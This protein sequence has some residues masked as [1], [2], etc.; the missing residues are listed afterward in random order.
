M[1]SFLRFI[2]IAGL[3]VFLAF[4]SESQAESTDKKEPGI[5]LAAETKSAGKAEIDILTAPVAVP[6]VTGGDEEK[7]NELAVYLSTAKRTVVEGIIAKRSELPDPRKSDYPNCRFTIDFIG[8]SIL[9]GEP[10]PREFV[11]V[12]DGFEN[13]KML[14]TDKLQE[15]D[16]IQCT[17]IPF[18]CLPEDNQSTQQADDL[19][20]FLLERYYVLNVRTIQAFED[21][22]VMPASAIF[23]SNEEKDYTSIFEL[24]L[25]PSIPQ[26]FIKKQ[27]D[28]ISA[29][30]ARMQ[31]LLNGYDEKT[32]RAVNQNFKVVWDREKEKDLPE[33]NRVNNCVWRN[34]DNSFW[35]LPMNYRSF[36]CP[37]ASLS[38]LSLSKDVLDCFAALNDVCKANNVLL[39]IS[40]VPNL[41]A[42]SSRVINKEF[43]EIPDLQTA[44]YVKQLSEIG[45]EAIYASDEII[46]NYSRYPFAF[47][48]PSNAHPFDTTQDVISD[49]LAERILDY[50][51]MP[52]LDPSLF[53][54]EM[55]TK[56]SGSKRNSFPGGCDV[57]NNKEGDLYAARKILYNGKDISKNKESPLMIVG[58]SFIQTPVSP[59]ESLPAILSYK[60]LSPV[61]WYC[62]AGYG[63][64]TNYIVQLI[65]RPDFF[66]KGK[67]V[68]II[69]FGTIHLEYINQNNGMLNISRLDTERLMF[70]K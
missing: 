23:F 32:I 41:Y 59:P 18:E 63:P 9:L 42:I 34:I 21:D 49:I 28:A 10:C 55:T 24:H 62:I 69:Q 20:L 52:E 5:I 1:K 36:P 60:T 16:K 64:F 15:G 65:S 38:D 66:L 31:G 30:L 53:A 13:Y 12:I 33:F 56:I 43:Q 35:C 8:N 29:N 25:N 26:E 58:N 45:I 44:L 14:E 70:K 4:Q 57:G 7:L 61:D 11:L 68:L 50:G 51:I 46:R 27:N 17:V 2:A 40:L 6:V 19:D 22:A 54:E 3:P 37:A 48:Y 67:K 39:I 47:Y